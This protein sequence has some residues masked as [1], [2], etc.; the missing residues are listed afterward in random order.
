[1]QQIW[2]VVPPE[3]VAPIPI[4]LSGIINWTS[5]QV[6]LNGAT[7]GGVR[8]HVRGLATADAGVVSIGGE[9]MFNPQ[10]EPPAR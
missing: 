3:P 1:M 7:A 4:Q 10:P 8:A 6:V 5:D 2:Q 9:L